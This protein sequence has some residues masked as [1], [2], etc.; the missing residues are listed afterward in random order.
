M[1]LKIFKLTDSFFLT[2]HQAFRSGCLSISVLK[3]DILCIE[4]KKLLFQQLSY[5][6]RYKLFYH[7]LFIIR[8][9]INFVFT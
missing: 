9:K 1:I 2:M 6:F 7:I 5:I 4:V 8:E 3:L